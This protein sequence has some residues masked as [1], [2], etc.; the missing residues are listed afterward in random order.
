M[1][2]TLKKK[3]ALV[4]TLLF[5]LWIL[6]DDETSGSTTNHH[7][8][9]ITALNRHPPSLRV[10]RSLLEL[11][12]LLWGT[13][14]SLFLWS[15]TIGNKMIGYLLFQPPTD[16][17][18]S[19]DGFFLFERSMGRY[20]QVNS[21]EIIME[22][23]EEEEPQLTE[24]EALD[25][26]YD[27]EGEVVEPR[28]AFDYFNNPPTPHDMAG[29]ALDSL[30]LILISLFFFTLSSA[31]GGTYVDGMATVNPFKF[32]ALITAPIFPLLLF[33]WGAVRAFSPWSQRRHFWKVVSLT[34]GAPMFHVTFRDGFI[35][36][37]LT[38]IVRPMQDTAFT[39]FYIFSGLQG[40]FTQSYGLNSADV[41]LETNWL[42][43]TCILPMC[44]VSP[45]W[46]RFL[47]NL[48][49]CWESKQRWPYLGNALKYFL[50]A[51]VAM[52]GVFN[53]SQKQ[54]VLWLAS[55]V[56]TTLYQIWWDVFM[57]W[58]LLEVNGTN[59]QLRR[60]RIYSNRWMY[61]TIFTINFVLR[62]FWTLS[63]LPQ[64][65]LSRAGVLSDNFDGDITA[66]LNPTIASAE[67][68]RRTLWGFLRVE[69]EA[70]KV[71]RKEPQL[72]GAW[73]DED[74][75]S[76][77]PLKSMS[78]KDEDPLESTI[79]PTIGWNTFDTTKDLRLLGELALYATAFTALGLLAA[80]H[81]ITY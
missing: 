34:V 19:Q 63:F 1:P 25:A 11:N 68:I 23:E 39:V 49:Q 35:G 61:W 22:E 70:I 81:R 73:E 53:P 64:H 51:Q 27:S 71:A 69:L 36:D 40:W 14:A 75:D 31:E 24:I 9:V 65:Y 37:I 42:L 55:F 44:M 6:S 72:R 80:A 54:S 20:R 8:A 77:I 79:L 59:V 76:G 74:P 26:D 57:D 43:R 28:I 56:T 45:L 16:N 67:I 38:S 33:I 50:A 58:E 7:L 21:D 17:T 12:L 15:K 2:L 30:I 60:T 10:Y 32:V 47:Q 46:Y 66:I 78:L 41:P 3:A 52:F 4:P 5:S 18:L 48:R 29:V 13:A 62:F